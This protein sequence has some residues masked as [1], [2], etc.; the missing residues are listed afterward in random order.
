MPPESPL[1]GA[2]RG[3]S[4]TRLSLARQ[5]CYQLKILTS[6]VFSV[7][8]ASDRFDSVCAFMPELLLLTVVDKVILL[9]KQLTT[10]KWISLVILTVGVVLTKYISSP[11]FLRAP[12]EMNGDWWTMSSIPL[13]HAQGQPI[14]GYAFNGRTS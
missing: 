1:A 6:A 3:S 12:H 8:S 2:C 11:S 4:V 14:Y 9:G 10:L 5:V 13:R 7:C